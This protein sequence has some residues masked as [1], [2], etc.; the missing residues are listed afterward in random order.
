MAASAGYLIGLLLA[1]L[2]YFLVGWME[3]DYY[4][5]RH[6]IIRQKLERIGES[7]R[8]GGS[9]EKRKIR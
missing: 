3:R 4:R 5:R 2:L 6:E 8:N 9:A 1:I 7:K